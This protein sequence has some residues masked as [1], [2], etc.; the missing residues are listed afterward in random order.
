LP[1]DPR[2]TRSRRRANFTT[3]R[4]ASGALFV[5][6][7]KIFLVRKTYGDHWDLPGGYV[8]R[9]E[10]PAAACEREVREELSLDVTAQRLLVHD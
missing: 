10:S 3:A 7:S 5:D 9:G 1:E 2:R 4:L 6:G 8:D